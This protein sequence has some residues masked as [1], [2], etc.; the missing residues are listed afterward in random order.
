MAPLRMEMAA[1]QR[2]ARPLPRVS[3]QGLAFLDCLRVTSMACRAKPRADL[4]EACAL[5]H[6][7]RS[8]S[9]SAHAEALMRCLN[10][11]LRK[12]PR[13]HA[14]GTDEM[15]FD[16]K[17][18]VQLGQANVRDDDASMA[19]LLQSRIVP[20]HQRLIKFLIGR[21]SESFALV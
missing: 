13:L 15:T 10:Q 17:W 20:E 21:I 7:T 3:P 12:H 14:P 11:A 1:D 6:A 19:F 2:R 18:L 9:V 16:E 8:A 4:F 5:L